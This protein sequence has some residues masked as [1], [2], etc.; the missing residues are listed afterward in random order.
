MADTGIGRNQS[1]IYLLFIGLLILIH[2][3]QAIEAGLFS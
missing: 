3:S 1:S 2:L